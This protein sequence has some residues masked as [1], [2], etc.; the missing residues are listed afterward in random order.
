MLQQMA[1]LAVY[2]I[3]K[4]TSSEIFVIEEHPFAYLL[5]YTVAHSLRHYR[6]CKYKG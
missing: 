5:G 2:Q 4:I 3:F 6:Q 1:A